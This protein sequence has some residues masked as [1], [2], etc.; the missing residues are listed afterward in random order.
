MI[1]GIKKVS[2]P[3]WRAVEGTCQGECKHA[4]EI[5]YHC[6]GNTKIRPELIIS[7]SVTCTNS[8]FVNAS[9]VDEFCLLSLLL[10]GI[11]IVGYPKVIL[12]RIFDLHPPLF[13]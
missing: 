3:E 11:R 8:V 6:H 4:L 1:K 12:K 2:G 10:F 7:E 13:V 5:P 9:S